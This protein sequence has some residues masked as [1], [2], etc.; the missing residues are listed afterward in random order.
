MTTPIILTVP[1]V[2]E[3]N[4]PGNYALFTVC[5]AGSVP[6]A[7]A[8]PCFGGDMNGV[9]GINGYL[10][11][12]GDC[13]SGSGN[14]Q[15]T[16]VYTIPPGYTDAR[17]AEDLYSFANGYFRRNPN[18]AGRTTI[19]NVHDNDDEVFTAFCSYLTD[20]PENCPADPTTGSRMFACSNWFV[21]GDP[22]T[23]ISALCRTWGQGNTGAADITM[24]NVCAAQSPLLSSPD[25]ACI[26]RGNEQYDYSY[27]LLQM[28][29]IKDCCW[30]IPC[31]DPN[32]Y[33]ITTDLNP[34]TGCPSDVTICEQIFINEAENR[35]QINEGQ[36]N[37]YINCGQQPETN[38]GNFYLI[39]GV[40]LAI[41]VLILIGVLY[42]FYN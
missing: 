2:V 26:N 1:I 33:L 38:N 29:G 39:I 11:D 31:K 3:N 7:T 12:T 6:F 24:Q 16:C 35:S 37:A 10:P 15:C 18:L 22:E 42:N 20:F 36:V 8:C 5:D 25:C 27:G 30:W 32:H 40:T 14:T 28:P 17:F 4:S 41:L 19:P 9:N 34:C 23:G 21:N 13:G